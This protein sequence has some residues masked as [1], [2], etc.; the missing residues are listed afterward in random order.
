MIQEFIQ[1]VNEL[2]EPGYFAGVVQCALKEEGAAFY[3]TLGDKGIVPAPGRFDG[4]ALARVTM[5][6]QV[7]AEMM[8][9]PETF[10]FRNS[11]FKKDIDVEGDVEVLFYLGELCRR[12]PAAAVERFR[13]AE[14]TCRRAPVH[15]I[16]TLFR[17]DEATLLDM[18][19]RCQP[20]VVRGMLDD[21]KPMSTPEAL[22]KAFGD[23]PLKHDA[24]GQLLTVAA[25]V[26]GMRSAKEGE[27]FH[28]GGIVLPE[29]ARRHYTMPYFGNERFNQPQ[30]WMGSATGKLAC[31]QLHRDTHHGFLGHLYGRKLFKVFS[32]DQAPY[33]YP[34]SAYNSHQNSWLAID[35][36]DLG[37]F[38][39]FA[40]AKAIEFVLEPGDL[41]V[42]PAGWF[43]SVFALDPVMSV[44]RFLND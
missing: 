34:K 17:P 40:K 19:E 2:Y 16:L 28:S 5:P 39:E 10:D 9:K 36:P 6:Q 33:L 26:D 44:S 23:L 7:L 37:R 4:D 15:E 35:R 24:K 32:P 27:R 22:V 31:T 1:R 29:D 14:E 43:H 41:L 21:W 18:I 20:V 42:M 8:T 38:P 25:F 3:L 11:L 30:L 12:P 13:K